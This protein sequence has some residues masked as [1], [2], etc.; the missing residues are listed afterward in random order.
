MTRSQRPAAVAVVVALLLGGCGVV[1]RPGPG[2]W[3]EHAAQALG[4]A[5]SQVATARLALRT[6]GEKR[7]WP[8]YAI[9]VV[10]QAEEAADTAEH[11]L[12][13]LQVP[14]EREAAAA[15]VLD[16]LARAADLV[17]VARAR[18]VDREYDDRA[19]L[20]ELDQLAA[21]LGRAAP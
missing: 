20:D 15:R 3:D 14:P 17:G 4:D 10:A 9:V 8:S 11:D 1:G 5:E 18:A 16:L 19:L 7:A 2:A 6:A 13:R 12:A 21:E